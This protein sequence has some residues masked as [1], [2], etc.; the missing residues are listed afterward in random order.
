[1]NTDLILILIC[2]VFI[3][4]L[5]HIWHIIRMDEMNDTLTWL[6]GRVDRLQVDQI[7]MGESDE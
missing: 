4:G 7:K 6:R 2:M 3:L 1:M 5:A